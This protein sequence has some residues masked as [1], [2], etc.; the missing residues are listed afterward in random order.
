MV[1][2]LS[3]VKQILE[4]D[5]R[6]LAKGITAIESSRLDH[7]DSADEL[8]QKLLPHTGNSIRIGISG[9]PGV[10]KSTFIESF[11]NHL[12]DIGHKVAD[13]RQYLNFQKH[14]KILDLR[15]ILKP[16]Q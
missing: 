1:E 16:K 6:A 9:A 4:G 13:I 15:K 14:N 7:R 12:V 8:L 5:R 10:G 11:G 2:N 3:L